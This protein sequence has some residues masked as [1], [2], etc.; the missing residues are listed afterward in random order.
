MEKVKKNLLKNYPILRLYKSDLEKIFKLFKDHYPEIE[1]VADGFKLD[2]FSE[3]SKINKQEIFDFEISAHN[4]FL[5]VDFSRNSARIY[6]SD[7]DDIK[8]RGLAD[9][10]ADILSERK[11]YL[12]FFA[13]PWTPNLICL[14]GFI[15]IFSLSKEVKTPLYLFPFYIL[16]IGLWYFWGIKIA[17]KKHSLIYLYDYSSAPSFFKRNKDRILLAILS[18]AIGGIITLII[19]LLLK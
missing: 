15:L 1:I 19:S 3:L 9:K 8:L 11:S 6:L 13:N 2:D 18:A 4:P 5:S 16:F 7:E 12:R 14:I 17:T 10:I